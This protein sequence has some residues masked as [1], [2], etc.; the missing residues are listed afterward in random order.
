MKKILILAYDFPPFLSVGA[1]RPYHWFLH[2]KEAGLMPI[3]VTRQWNEQYAGKKQYVAP[4]YSDKVDVEESDSGIIIR[5]PYKP[6]LS[7]R[8]LLK[9][10][11]N[12]YRRIR[13]LLTGFV[14]IFQWRFN[15]GPRK[16][17][18]NEAKEYLDKNKVDVII[19]TGEP[20]ILFKFAY[21][22]SQKFNIPWIADYRDP[23]IDPNV[24]QN[25][26]TKFLSWFNRRQERRLLKS[27]AF[28]SI[29]S[30][31]F[32]K[33]VSD[34]VGDKDFVISPNGFDLD[35]NDIVPIQQSLDKFI[36]TY[37]GRIYPYY[38]VESFFEVADNFIK[39]EQIDNLE[40]RFIGVSGDTDI[41]GLID[42]KFPELKK[43]VKIIPPVLGNNLFRELK[44]SNLLLLFNMYSI[45]G[46]KIYNYIAANRQIIQCFNEDEL[47]LKL[48]ERFWKSD[49][50]DLYPASR[51]IVEK[52]AGVVVKDKEH[53]YECFRKFYQEHKEKGFVQC[54]A[55]DISEYSR[56]EL[57]KKLACIILEQIK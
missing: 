11:E 40:I 26:Q 12:R 32:K 2:F 34:N 7:N 47:G 56:K 52:N 44:V 30:K 23:W 55:G 46:T 41:N 1:I 45:I 31:Y 43:Y 20:F 42:L 6:N 21:K 25:L 54:N 15:I 36:I 50:L 51:M 49:W 19:A 18:Y 37:I 22:L 24:N 53:L 10:G 9:Y 27:A 13:K 14:E 38:P 3:V 39:E 57:S 29:T 4:G 17:I 33:I 16:S 5:A 35:V 8:L 28:A 48:K